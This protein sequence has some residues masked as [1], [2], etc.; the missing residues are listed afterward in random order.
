VRFGRLCAVSREPIAC[1]AEWRTE[2]GRFRAAQPR[3]VFPLGVHVGTPAGPRCEVEVAWPVPAQY[4]AG[5]RFD[6]V[7]ALVERWAAETG[8]E[9]YGWVTRPGVPQLHDHDV[10]WHAATGRAFGACGLELLGFRA[11]TRT[12]WVDVVTGESQAWRRLRL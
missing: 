9:A 8:G 11:V 5:L 6:V 7:S 12:G 3:R 2:V 1:A 10:E 4:D